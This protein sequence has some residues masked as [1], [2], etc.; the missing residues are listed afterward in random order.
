MVAPDCST[1]VRPDRIGRVTHADATVF[2]AVATQIGAK[3][4]LT[5]SPGTLIDPASLLAWTAGELDLSQERQIRD[6]YTIAN[7]R[8]LDHNPRF[9]LWCYIR[10]RIARCRR[11]SQVLAP[12]LPYWR[13]VGG[14]AASHSGL[15]T[16]TVPPGLI[17][18]RLAFSDLIEDLY[19]PIARDGA[20][21]I[22]VGIRL[23]K[24]LAALQTIATEA[25]ADCRTEAKDELVRGRTALNS[26]SNRDRIPNIHYRYWSRGR[27]IKHYLDQVAKRSSL[28]PFGNLDPIPVARGSSAG[29]LPERQFIRTS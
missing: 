22:E 13:R 12:L 27:A 1:I 11:Q 25:M 19:R 20:G 8:T 14:N 3:I 17:I 7:I 21:T 24:S 28:K 15:K 2:A 16:G 23:Q 26:A 29:S 5:A 18:L 9:G 4:S 6:T 10:K